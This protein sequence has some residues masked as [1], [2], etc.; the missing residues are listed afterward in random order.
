MDHDI[1]WV[2]KMLE[3][4]VREEFEKTLREL[5]M[6]GI[7]PKTIKDFTQNFENQFRKIKKSDKESKITLLKLQSMTGFKFGKKSS[8]KVIR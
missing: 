4:I 1:I 7:D 3:I 5:S 2:N 8:T 6:H